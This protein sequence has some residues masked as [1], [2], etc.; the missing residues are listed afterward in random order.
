MHPPQPSPIRA[1]DSFINNL[2]H[3]YRRLWVIVIHLA[4]VALA[5]HLAFLLRF[6]A[7]VPARE[8]ALQ[9]SMLPWLLAMRGILFFP[10]GVYQGLWRYVGMWDLRNIIASILTSSFAFLLLMQF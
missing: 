3:R 4:L 7:D 1:I 2:S 6:D 8:L 5:N 9:L 10:F